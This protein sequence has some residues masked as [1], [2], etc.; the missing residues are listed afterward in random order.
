MSQLY[1]V[2]ITLLV[3]DGGDKTDVKIQGP[4]DTDVAPEILDNKDGT[5]LIEF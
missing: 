5:Y 3:R 1:F 2:L 4:Y